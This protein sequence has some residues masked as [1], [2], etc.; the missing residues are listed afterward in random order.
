MVKS[1]KDNSPKKG[2][3]EG[4]PLHYHYRKV[5]N[6]VLIVPQSLIRLFSIFIRQLAITM[7]VNTYIISCA[8]HRTARNRLHI[9]K[10]YT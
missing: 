7:L 8:K 5:P 10:S 6:T 2:Q 4:Y 9:R 3:E 1:P